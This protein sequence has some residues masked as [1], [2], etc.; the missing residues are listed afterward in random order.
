MFA[1]GLSYR[2]FIMLRYLPSTLWVCFFFFI[3]KDVVFCPVCLIHLLR[4]S[5]MVFIFHSI[6]V[7]CVIC[8]LES[9]EPFLHPRDK[10]CLIIAY[11]H[12]QAWSKPTVSQGPSHWCILL[13]QHSLFLTL[14]KAVEFED[15]CQDSSAQVHSWWEGI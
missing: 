7:V 11:D 2:A 1:E 10:S 4:W 14:H 3:M 8:W 5:Y 12:M 9:V 6:N 15:R 13:W